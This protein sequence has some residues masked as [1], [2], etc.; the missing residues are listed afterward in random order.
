[1]LEWTLVL[2]HHL[3]VRTVEHILKFLMGCVNI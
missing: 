3:V 2:E 1:M